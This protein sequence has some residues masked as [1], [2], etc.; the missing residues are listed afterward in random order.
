MNP[1]ISFTPLSGSSGKCGGYCGLLE[2]GDSVVL[3]DCGTTATHLSLNTA[4][5]KIRETLASELEDLLSQLEAHSARISAVLLSHG[6]FAHMGALP[7]VAK[8]LR[9]PLR[10][11]CTQPALKMA[12]MALYDICIGLGQHRTE[13]ASGNEC[14]KDDRYSFS[15][16]D[17]DLCFSDVQLVKYHQ[18]AIIHVD[19]SEDI[20][21]C[22]VN[23]GRTVGG[24]AWQL[25]RGVANVFYAVGL[26]LKK[27]TVLDGA[28]I[29]VFP[30]S[31]SLLI[32]DSDVPISASSTRYRNISAYL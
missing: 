23:A 1:E 8:R 32:T 3:L 15:L 26:N 7:L 11:I 16:D 4:D 28:D 29:S 14:A 25:V 31:P 13:E 12:Q 27:E 10:I 20:Q 22:A 24:A 2:M 5:Q 30:L 19:G 9:R 18:Q 6:D 21:I 17:I